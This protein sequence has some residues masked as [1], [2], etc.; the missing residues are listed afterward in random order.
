MLKKCV[1][2][3]FLATAYSV[4]LAHNFTPHH[5]ANEMVHQHD[6]GAHHEHGKHEHENGDH[7][8]CNDFELL[9]HMGSPEPSFTSASPTVVS[10]KQL[11]HASACFSALTFVISQFEK[12]PL[13]YHRA[14]EGSPFISVSL[15]YFFSLKA[16]PALTLA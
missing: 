15:P 4:L 2:F 5:H 3:L 14:R 16:P 1:I 6:A 12:P 11:E 8:L 10:L 7:G 13:I 9:D